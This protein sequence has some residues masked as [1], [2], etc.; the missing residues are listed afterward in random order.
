MSLKLESWIVLA[1]ISSAD[2]N[3]LLSILNPYWRKGQHLH[4]LTV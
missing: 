1:E 3:L 2:N 4:L